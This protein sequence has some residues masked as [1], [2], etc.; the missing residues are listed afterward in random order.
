MRDVLA[1]WPELLY[2]SVLSTAGGY[3]LQT[4]GQRDAKPAHAAIVLSMES[5]FSVL[6][7][8][9]FLGERMRL[10]GYLGCA[11]M[12]AAVLISQMSGMKSSSASG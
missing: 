10:T 5:V 8:A 3:T 12:L 2:L 4:I 6:G 11:I 9:V 7:G 1:V